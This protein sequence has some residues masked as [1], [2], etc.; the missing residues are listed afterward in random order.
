MF[1]Y[2]R[3]IFFLRDSASSRATSASRMRF[4]FSGTISILLYTRSRTAAL[5]ASEREG[6]SSTA[7]RKS[8]AL[9]N[10]VGRR[11]V[12]FSDFSSKGSPRCR[13]F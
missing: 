12:S 2:L 3:S 13:S 10:R 8:R 6:K 7:T 4:I 5:M 9:M 11:M 1:A